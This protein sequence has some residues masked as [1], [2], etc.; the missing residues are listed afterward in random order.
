MSEP[1]DVK[2]LV[3]RGMVAEF[4]RGVPFAPVVDALDPYLGTLDPK[5]L[6]LPEGE[7]RDE[8]GAIFPSLRT[9]RTPSTGVH[10]ERYRAYR[11]SASCWSGS[12]RR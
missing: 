7:L 10:D 4:E 5:R 9:E 8:L 6:R 3:L 1:R 12:P 2:Y 11:P